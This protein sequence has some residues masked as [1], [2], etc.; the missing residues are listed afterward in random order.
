[1][2]EREERPNRPP[3]EWYEFGDED[4]LSAKILF[5]SRGPSSTIGMLV[6]Q[7]IEKYLKGFLIG[8]GWELI[9]THNIEFLLA[10]SMKHDPRFE[11]F[12]D[13][14]RKV[15]ELYAADRYPARNRQRLSEDETIELIET[16]ERVIGMVTEREGS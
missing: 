1:M 15:S 10:E 11:E 5:N 4:F 2:A 9:K 12:L 16:G 3:S 6:Q 13:F 8:R 7:A 14:G